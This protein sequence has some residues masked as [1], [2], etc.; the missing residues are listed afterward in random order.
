MTQIS[1]VLPFALPPPELA[2]DLVRA[3][4]TP[5]LAFLTSRTSARQNL[6]VDDALRAL[7]HEAWLSRTLGFDTQGRAVFAAA[8]MRAFGLVPGEGTWF[9]I[10]PAHIEIA[11]SHLLM[12][13]LRRTQLSDA[14]ARALFATAS[15]Y[16]EE[17]GKTLLYGA[18]HTWFMRADD[19]SDLDTATPDAAIGQNL[20]DWLPKG[21]S[22]RAFRQLQN[23]V[24][25]LWF[26]HP[27][28]VARE[29]QGLTAIN[30]FW[31]WGAG[32]N[33][34]RS[35]ALPLAT[36]DA[37][38]WLAALAQHPAA[39]PATL[40]KGDA[41]DTV[42]VCDS[43][44]GP[45]IRTDWASWLQ[46][47]QQLEQKVFAPALA[48]LNEG[49]IKRLHLILSHRNAQLQLTTTKLAQHAF[50]RRPGLTR[51]LP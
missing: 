10:H 1:L 49:R 14:D 3:L 24:Q 47:M 33:N 27:V 8:A 7:P 13:D 15:P 30:S 35:N 31:P 29:A 23:E 11:R 9:L 2:T 43:L 17:A 42:L 38:P 21:P 39:N 34:A 4:Q 12:N 32:Q 50:W 5:S 26:E 19:W 44:T 41:G 36:M 6:P 28:N 46:Q 18:P 37:Q 48:A 45:A 25:M 22:A 51:L 40:F 16:F 20:T